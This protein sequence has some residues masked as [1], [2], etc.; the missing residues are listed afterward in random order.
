VT[1]ATRAIR[2]LARELGY[3]LA[4]AF[5]PGPDCIDLMVRLR[6]RMRRGG[7][8]AAPFLR[9]CLEHLAG[10]RS[11]MLQDLWVLYETQG[12][13]GGVFVEFGA[14]DGLAGSNSYM[15][16][17]GYGWRGLLVEPARSWHGELVKNRRCSI[18]FRCVTDRTGDQVLFR[19]C[20]ERPL[21]TIE[22]YRRA[23]RFG[24]KRSRATRYEVET[25]SLD[26]LLDQHGLEAVDY[27]SVDTEGSELMLLTPFDFQRFRP[28]VITVEHGYERRRREG[29]FDLLSQHGY[30][31]EHES[32]SQID[33][34]Y[35]RGGS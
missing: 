13:R 28:R 1:L 4:R 25:V 20:A 12:L 16:E 23:D 18:D 10:S 17:T 21:S 11:D 33:D 9:F 34:W 27:L 35:V 31:R 8:A 3:D 30:R 29:L 7:D 32:L 19:D 2:R 22:R 5:P 6:E 14:A 15:L 26:D 24:G